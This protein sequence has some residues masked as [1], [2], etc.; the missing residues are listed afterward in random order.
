VD[1]GHEKFV[2]VSEAK[3]GGVDHMSKILPTPTQQD[4]E[5]ALTA[6]RDGTSAYGRYMRLEDSLQYVL[7]A[8]CDG[9]SVYSRCVLT[10]D[11]L[12]ND[13]RANAE[14]DRL[15]WVDII[16]PDGVEECCGGG[17]TSSEAAA[18]AWINNFVVGWWSKPGLSEEDDA[19]VPRHVP[20]GWQFELYA[21]P[22]RHAALKVIQGSSDPMASEKVSGGERSPWSDGH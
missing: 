11:S 21:A 14:A 2:G 4:I 10:D 7:F 12:A 6:M 19:K 5:A 20:E 1:S 9:R 17:T 3:N 15:W 13:Y 8:I 16:N 18:V 22:V